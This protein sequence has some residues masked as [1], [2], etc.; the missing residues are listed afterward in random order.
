MLR[1]GVALLPLF[2]R[3]TVWSID[4][5]STRTRNS[6]IAP[7]EKYSRDDEY[8]DRAK[9]WRQD[10]QCTKCSLK[11]FRAP[12]RIYRQCVYVAAISLN[13]NT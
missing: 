4:Q 9:S 7:C 11:Q 13:G 1:K 12:N 3:A 6:I 10:R 2:A 5:A 8:G